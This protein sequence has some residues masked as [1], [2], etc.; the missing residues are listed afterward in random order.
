MTSEE[1]PAAHVR[2]E[3]RT[4]GLED[5]LT[6][7]LRAVYDEPTA[8]AAAA[9]LRERVE[10]FLTDPPQ[11][12][13]PVPDQREVVLITYPDQVREHGRAPLATLR[14]LIHTHL[15]DVVSTVHLLPLHPW[16]S[17]DGFSVSD[18][19]QVDPAVGT[20]E[21]V[22]AYRP[23]LGLMLD[24]VV[25]HVSAAHPWVL[26]WREGD[27]E[28][29]GFVRTAD[30]EDDLTPVVR[31][32][33]SPLLTPMETVRGTEHVW[34]TF[35]ADQVDLDYRDPKVLLAVTDVLLDYIR[36]GATMLRLDAVAF[37][38]KKV[39]SDSIH[40]PQTHAIVRLWRTV[41]DAAAPGTLIVT[42]TNVPHREN[43]TYLGRGD[44]Q[45][46]VVYQFALAPL[47]LS[48]F[49]SGDARHLARW[50]RSLPTLQR[51]TTVLNVLGSHDGI[52][53]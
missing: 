47:V 44:D 30:P 9:A 35:S 11:L 50:A 15:A 2:R 22:E 28:H 1:A 10:R 40:R 38:W 31:P 14:Q 19:S 26:R 48:A 39:G 34:T 20:W 7:D 43:L 12:T 46:H 25:N 18:Y 37:L 33:A 42:E 49:T 29:A 27:P 51:G 17:D 4:A 45:A 52:G 3:R 23:D 24:A 36:H 41:V 32:R 16:T 8:S 53:L 6:Y 5:R 13:P 21:E